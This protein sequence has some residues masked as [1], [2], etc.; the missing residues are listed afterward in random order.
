[1]DMM[2]AGRLSLRKLNALVLSIPLLVDLV[3]VDLALG[4]RF[5]CQRKPGRRVVLILESERLLGVLR[6]PKLAFVAHAQGRV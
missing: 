5:S 6:H 2:T 4:A 3:L 1:M